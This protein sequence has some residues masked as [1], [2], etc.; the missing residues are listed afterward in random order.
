MDT[1]YGS[2]YYVCVNLTLSIDE[3]IVE[4]AREVA[5]NQGMSLNEL[6]RRYLEGVAGKRLTGEA[7]ATEW[8][9]QTAA[10]RAYLARL[11]PDPEPVPE[12]YNR[13]DAYDPKRIG[14]D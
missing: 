9:R 6:I 13:E 11:P 7:A 1:E 14:N 4:Q 5:R 3:Q 12:K 8:R 10:V 2:T